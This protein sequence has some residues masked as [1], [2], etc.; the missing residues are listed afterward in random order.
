MHCHTKEGSLDGRIPLEDAILQLQKKG[1][2]GMLITDHNSYRAYRHYK[3]EIKD[4][5]YQDFVV[6]KGIEYDTIDA[7][8]ILVIMPSGVKLPILELRGLPVSLLIDVVHHFGGILGPAHPCGEKYLSLMH[9]RYGRKHEDLCARFDFIETFNACES[10]ASNQKAAQLSKRFSKPGIGGSDF[11]RTGCIGMGYTLIDAM[12]KDETDFIQALRSGASIS[13]GGAYYQHTTKQKI[14]KA[15][16]LLLYSFW[17]YNRLS[18]LRRAHKR[19]RRL[20][21]YMNC[22]EKLH[23]SSISHTH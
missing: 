23:A 1:F 21:E 20:K 17:F 3:K 9:T 2:H 13:S 12:I 6:L 18:A 16:H 5:K 22:Y 14:G 7:G 11:H 10:P 4:K 15:N 19:N 8:H